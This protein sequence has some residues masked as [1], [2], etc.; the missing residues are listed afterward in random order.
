MHSFKILESDGLFP[1]EKASF[2]KYEFPVPK[3]SI[4]YARDIYGKRFIKI[5]R[6]KPKQSRLAYLGEIDNMEDMLRISCKNLKEFNDN[7]DF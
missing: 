3:D 4:S 2:G 1:L 5:P 6:K 7:H